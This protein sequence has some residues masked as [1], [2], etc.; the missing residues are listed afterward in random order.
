VLA[1]LPHG[2]NGRPS[3]LRDLPVSTAQLRPCERSRK[4]REG[5][6]SPGRRALHGLRSPVR[7]LTL[8]IV[9]GG[10]ECSK[11]SRQTTRLRA[12]IAYYRPAV[13]AMCPRDRSA[14][15]D[16]HSLPRGPGTSCGP[17]ALEGASVKPRRISGHEARREKRPS[18]S[19]PTC[20][21]R[22]WAR[23]ASRAR[24][25]PLKLVSP[26]SE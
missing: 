21:A 22:P 18:C 5:Q 10:K 4:A 9:P 24:T 7:K 12:R 15:Q 3:K 13:L 14:I 11:A 6:G 2:R 17:M 19:A 8:R 20:C 25:S 23:A 26:C 1:M 16:V